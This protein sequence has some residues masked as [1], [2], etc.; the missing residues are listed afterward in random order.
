MIRKVVKGVLKVEVG[1]S[2]IVV[3]V[4]NELWGTF[5]FF[6]IVGRLQ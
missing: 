2:E 6:V 1:N 5:D 3:G 4:A